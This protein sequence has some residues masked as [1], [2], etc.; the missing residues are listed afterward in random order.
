LLRS[1]GERNSIYSGER[2]QLHGPNV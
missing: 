2:M 1:D